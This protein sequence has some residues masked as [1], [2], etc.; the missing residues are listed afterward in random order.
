M[1]H[2][3]TSPSDEADVITRTNPLCDII[4]VSIAFT[5]HVSTPKEND[6]HTERDGP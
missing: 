5:L 2:V 6:I 3:F 1:I 4:V